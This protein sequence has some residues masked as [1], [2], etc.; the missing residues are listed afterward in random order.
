MGP[1]KKL[2]ILTIVAI[3]AAI[4]FARPITYLAQ[5]ARQAADVLALAR[6]AIGDRKLDSLKT[7]SVEYSVQRNVGNMQINSD[8]ETFPADSPDKLATF[9]ERAGA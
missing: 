8:V 1:M 4:A 6:K 2:R 5:E 9:K 3:V 7:F